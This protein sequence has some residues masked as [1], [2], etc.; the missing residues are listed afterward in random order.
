MIRQFA[1]DR[2]HDQREVTDQEILE[3][4]LYPMIN[5]GAKILEE[6][7]AIRGSDVD[8]VDKH[9]WPLYER[10]MHWAG[11]RACRDRRQDLRLWR[12]SGGRQ[13]TIAA[14]RTPADEGG[15]LAGHQGS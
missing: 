7:I 13:Q 8:V 10:P 11:D 5:E 3:R 14:A 6:G 1:I 4:L 2:G 15:S 9:G 12:S